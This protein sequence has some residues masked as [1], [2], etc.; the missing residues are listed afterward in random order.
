MAAN[1]GGDFTSS[2]TDLMTSLAI[3]FLIL[4]VGLVIV[5][6]LS[7]SEI[8]AIGKKYL[9]G[10]QRVTNAKT[11]LI[12][13]I[14][15]VFKL[16]A[17]L[18]G[19][20]RTDD[21][22]VV[23]TADSLTRLVIRFND[24]RE[25]C[26]KHGLFFEENEFTIDKRQVDDNIEKLVKFYAVFCGPRKNVEIYENIQNIQIVGHTDPILFRSDD[27]NCGKSLGG[28]RNQRSKWTKKAA[29]ISDLQCGN[30]YLSSQRA[31]TI[32]MLIG[33]K[34]LGT[35]NDGFFSCFKDMTH[36]VGRGPFE[37]TNSAFASQTSSLAHSTQ[38]RVEIVFEFK[39]PQV[40]MAVAQD[41]KS[42][43]NLEDVPALKE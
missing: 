34:I 18:D 27:A 32:F 37:P 14:V 25:V 35:R 11:Q 12:D 20:F 41:I 22:C 4:A 2:Y 19:N 29:M 13:E 9:L 10:L 39:A 15:K 30:L 36:S 16:K 40:D 17:D 8:M 6:S 23:V 7:Q 5:V 33:E 38:R 43:R 26:K 28:D 31:R 42:N 24:D 1:E 21:D 3:V